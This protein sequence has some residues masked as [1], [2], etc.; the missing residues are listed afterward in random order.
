MCPYSVTLPPGHTAYT[1]ICRSR[2]E[3]RAARRW[4]QGTAAY[5]SAVSRFAPRCAA[6][7]C[8]RKCRRV[9]SLIYCPPA[10]PYGATHCARRRSRAATSASSEAFGAR[11]VQAGVLAVST[12]LGRRT[13]GACRWRLHNNPTFLRSFTARSSERGARR[14]R[15]NMLREVVERVL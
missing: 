13:R 4:M 15:H 8:M 5:V 1:T 14:H 11:R 3:V 7:F 6:A 12:M 9:R 10:S 2:T